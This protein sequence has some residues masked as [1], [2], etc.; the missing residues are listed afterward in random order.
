MF[1][2]KVPARNN[3]KKKKRISFRKTFFLTNTSKSSA[4][5]FRLFES[6]A[7]DRLDL[8]GRTLWENGRNGEQCPCVRGTRIDGEIVSDSA[9]NANGSKSEDQ[10]ENE[11]ESLNF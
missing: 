6:I 11:S 9:E 5:E 7:D 4:H 1:I 8:D 10:L 2:L 3:Q